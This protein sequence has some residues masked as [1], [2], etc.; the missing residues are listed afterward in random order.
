MT[1][2]IEFVP[3]QSNGQVLA[4]KEEEDTNMKPD[5]NVEGQKV[6]AEKKG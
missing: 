3:G 4:K 6:Q 2:L 1:E 5:K